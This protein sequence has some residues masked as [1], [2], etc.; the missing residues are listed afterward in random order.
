M[1]NSLKTLAVWGIIGVIFIVLISSILENNDR[2]LSYSELVQKIE[3]NEVEH[4]EINSSGDSA[5]V[6][7]K[8]NNGQKEVNIPNMENFMDTLE[9]PMKNGQVDVKE[10]SESWFMV[11]LGLLTP[12][13]IL[14]IFF[15][16]SQQFLLGTWI[17]FQ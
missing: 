16:F 1:K 17:V 13:G 14:I 9:E 2:K 5:V 7:L 15:L 6:K 11:I 3:A 12:F 8:E 4:I 10:K